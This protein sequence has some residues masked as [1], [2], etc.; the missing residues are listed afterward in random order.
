MSS[1]ELFQRLV[2]SIS[3]YLILLSC[4][5]F[6]RFQIYTTT[7]IPKTT[8]NLLNPPTT[9]CTYIS[10]QDLSFNGLKFSLL[11]YS[12]KENLTTNPKPPWS[13]K[14]T[15]DR[16]LSP[17]S[18][19]LISG[20]MAYMS[21]QPNPYSN[22]IYELSSKLKET[23]IV[24]THDQGSIEELFESALAVGVSKWNNSL[25]GKFFA[26]FNLSENQVIGKQI[27]FGT[28]SISLKLSN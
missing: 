8:I 2:L 15:T 25:I 19:D 18:H 26:P 28:N 21:S 13:G 1:F 22:K 20:P 9:C 5:N 23:S 17:S 14:I 24:D 27:V 6:H 4:I 3:L 7:L 16:F 11:N 10:F 12:I